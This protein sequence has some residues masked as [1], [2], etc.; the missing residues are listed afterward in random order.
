[1][2]TGSRPQRGEVW[3][4]DLDPVRGHEQAGTRPILIISDNIFN[5]SPAQLVIAL[6]L[7]S[8]AKNVRVHIL[9][10]PPEGGLTMQSFIKCEDIRSLSIDRLCNRIGYVEDNTLRDVEY[11]LRVLLKL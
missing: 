3:R 11:R 8:K 9:V 5:S 7:T 6:P 4:A 2:R 1:M 10:E